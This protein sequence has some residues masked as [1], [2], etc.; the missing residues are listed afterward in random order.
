[1]KQD[2]KYYGVEIVGYTAYTE[3][4]GND[5]LLSTAYGKQRNDFEGT[6]ED[7]LKYIKDRSITDVIGVLKD[8][9]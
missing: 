4:L 7:C 8:Q 2:S 6:K 3:C 9:V 5:D 1:M